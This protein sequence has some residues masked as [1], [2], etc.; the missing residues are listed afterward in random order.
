MLSV[1][2]IQKGFETIADSS[3]RE[4]MLAYIKGHFDYYG[5]ACPAR[6]ERQK[7]SLPLIK[8]Q[9]ITEQWKLIS[10]LYEE[11]LR[12]LHYFAIDFLNKIPVKAY[13]LNDMK[14]VEVLLTK[15]HS[16]DSIDAIASNFRGKWFFFEKA[17]SGLK[18]GDKP[19]ISSF[20][21]HV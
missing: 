16:W 8:K 5:S 20:T 11:P 13:S 9:P 6:K 1:S 17:G 10:D 15:S 18:R 7:D 3:K 2:E 12:V 21:Q 14:K 4:G 19:M